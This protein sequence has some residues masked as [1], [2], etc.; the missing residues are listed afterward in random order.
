MV[1]YHSLLSKICNYNDEGSLRIKKADYNVFDVL[2][3]SRKEVIMCRFFADLLNPDG[4]H[5]YGILFLK[6]F[7]EEVL[8]IRGFNDGLLT[9]TSVL[10]LEYK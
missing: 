5:G 8:K 7:L 10:V 3:V 1:Q 2:G 6:T 4:A 9:H